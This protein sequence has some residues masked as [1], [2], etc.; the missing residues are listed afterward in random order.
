M[1]EEDG[2][3]ERLWVLRKCEEHYDGDDEEEEQRWWRR[4]SGGWG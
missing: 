2:D 1:K 3:G 4:G